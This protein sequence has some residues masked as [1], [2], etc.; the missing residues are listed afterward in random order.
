MRRKQHRPRPNGPGKIT[1]SA[2]GKKGYPKVGGE[3][4]NKDPSTHSCNPEVGGTICTRSCVSAPFVPRPILCIQK[5][6]LE[7]LRRMAWAKERAA[8]RQQKDTQ[9]TT[10]ASRAHMR[11]QM[12]TTTQPGNNTRRNCL[13]WY[14]YQRCSVRHESKWLRT[15]VT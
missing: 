12:Y 13:E 5:A 6:R 15:T 14:P 10:R 8:R 4:S 1:I 3:K 2:F 9:L 11:L 7:R